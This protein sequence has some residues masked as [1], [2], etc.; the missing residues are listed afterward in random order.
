MILLLITILKLF[1]FSKIGM[2]LRTLYMA[3]E[4]NIFVSHVITYFVSYVILQ[5]L[6][7]LQTDSIF[8][9]LII[10]IEFF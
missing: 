5:L 7:F 10:V 8:V 3:G 6:T 4:G 9:Y 2:A 1:V